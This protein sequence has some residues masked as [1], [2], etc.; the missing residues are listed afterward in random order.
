MLAPALFRERAFGVAV[1]AALAMYAALFG[2]LYFIAQFLQIALVTSPLQT[3]VR[4]LPMAIMPML[5]SPVGGVLAD[6]FGTRVVLVAG[7]L[8]EV[9]G[10]WWL[11]AVAGPD[12][13]YAYLVPGLVFVGVGSGLF[14]APVMSAAIADVPARLNRQAAGAFCAVREFAA[15]LGVAVLGLMFGRDGDANPATRLLDGFG[16]AMTLAGGL[17]AAGALL[18][19]CAHARRPDRT[20]GATACAARGAG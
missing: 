20:A 4:L 6:R 14:F 7:L 8:C 18:V 17:A 2:G 10:L 5:V 12:V 16:S 13:G 19:L 15:V 11:A 1:G 9:T 3:G